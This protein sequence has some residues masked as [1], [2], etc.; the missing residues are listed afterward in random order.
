MYY[1]TVKY[2]MVLFHILVWQ[3]YVYATA[4]HL[5]TVKMVLFHILV[6][7]QKYVYATDLK[8]LGGKNIFTPG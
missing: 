1:S 3:K 7:W 4:M 6:R 2:I 8:N 5:S